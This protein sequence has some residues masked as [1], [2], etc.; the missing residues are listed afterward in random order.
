MK[1]WYQ[2][3]NDKQKD[4]ICLGIPIL[5]SLTIKLILL[6][7]LFDT[8]VNNDA[9]VYINSAKL[10]VMGNFADG[11]IVYPMP[12]YPL[13]LAFIHIFIPDW[14]AAGYFISLVSMILVTI[15]LY[16][17]T[18]TMFGSKAGFWACLVFSVLPKMNQWSIDIIR[19]P[20]F[21]LL[22]ISCI[23][24]ALRSIKKSDFYLFGLTFVL[25][26]SATLIRIE[27]VI[28]IGFYSCVLIYFAIVDTDNRARFFSRSLIWVGIPIGIALLAVLFSGYGIA[29][30]RFDHVLLELIGFFNGNFLTNSSQIG[31]FLSEAATKPPFFDGSYSFAALCR[32]FLPIIYLLGIVQI[33]VKILFPLLLIPL[34]IGFKV[35]VKLPDYYGKFILLV[36]ILFA[37]LGYYFLIKY[38]FIA[39]RYLMIPAFLLLPWIG[40]GLDRLCEIV[41]TSPYKKI[42]VFL[43]LIIILVPTGKTLRLTLSKSKGITTVQTVQWL[44]ENDKIN[45]VQIV[46]NH[47]K[48]SLYIDLK[49]KA[50]SNW[51]TH[52]YDERNNSLSVEEFALEKSAEIIVLKKK[53]KEID[54]VEDFQFYQKVKSFVGKKHYSLIYTRIPNT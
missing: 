20:L 23:Y 1:I 52:Y 40:L 51:K 44:I 48:V 43:I 25:A 4:L 45:N 41:G 22:F 50:D 12:A 29:V 13:L 3:S 49:A 38:D 46:S 17:L 47:Y 14:I 42:L 2:S 30:N 34:Y 19:D 53:T 36:W 10:Y 32:H 33:L 8:P 54:K 15:P 39:T 28:F 31:Q 27:G 5:I 21:L 6:I 7:V 9:A 16:Y 37:G 26:W 35:K 18:K 11:M 24:F